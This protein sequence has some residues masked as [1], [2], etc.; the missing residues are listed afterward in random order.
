VNILGLSY[1]YHDAAACIVR[2]GAPLA[3][4]EE[5]RFSRRKHDARFPELA[6]AYCLREAGLAP[7]DLDGIAFYEKPARKLE[8]VLRIAKE[9]APASTACVAAQFPLL[10]NEG[11]AV[12]NTVREKLNYHGGFFFNEHHLSHAASAFYLSPFDEAAILTVDGVGEWA[13]CAQFSGCGASI[14]KHREIHYPHSLGLLYS[15][16]TAFLGF[17]VNDDEYKIMGLA[18]YGEPRFRAELDQLLQLHADGSFSLALPYF[19]YMYDHATMHSAEMERLLG[20]PRLPGEPI[21]ERHRNIAASLQAVLNDAM[22]SIAR[23]CRANQAS[24]NLCLAG[25]VAYNCVANSKILE[26]KIFDRVFIQPAAGDSGAALG[27]ALWATHEV[28]GAPRRRAAQHDTMLGPAFTESEMLDF[29]HAF[30]LQFVRLDEEAL[31]RKVAALIYKDM[32]VGWFQGRMEFGPR[33]L[34]SRSILANPCSPRMKDIL[35]ARVKFR[36]EFRPFAPAV[37]EE[38]AADYFELEGSS[39]FM[40]LTPPVRPGRAAQ[41][42]SVTHVDGT[43]RVQTVSAAQQPLFHRLIRSFGDLSG[44]P[45]VINTSFNIRGEPIVCT[46]GDAIKCFLGTD[47]DFLAIGPFLVSKV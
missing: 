43:A 8:R 44:V 31:C 39:P 3:A 40:L 30:A 2:D 26:H 47:I 9:Y 10:I 23:S 45:I 28:L 37:L 38:A 12:E 7:N 25:G 6:I 35:N 24:A 42:P 14:R 41:I 1:N 18:S 19:S 17:K 20:K 16:L 13:T 32:V 36:E 22:L 46:P 21:E 27:A 34:G 29:L 5:E 15:T 33:A 4:A 11:M